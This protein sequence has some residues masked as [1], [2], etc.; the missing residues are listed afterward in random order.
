VHAEF[1]T[2]MVNNIGKEQLAA[3]EDIKIGGCGT[4]MWERGEI[5]WAANNGLIIV[6]VG[7]A[8]QG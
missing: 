7:L 4:R 8:I 5:A 3:V 1:L 6:C 2:A